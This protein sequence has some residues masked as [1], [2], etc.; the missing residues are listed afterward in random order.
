MN[1]EPVTCAEFGELLD[2]Y[3]DVGPVQRAALDA[4]SAGC[5]TCRDAFVRAT[6]ELSDLPCR[7]FVEL[8]TDYLERAMSARERARVSRHLEL[9]EGCRSYLA[10]IRTTIELAATPAEPPDPALRAALVAAFR[11]TRGGS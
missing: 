8:V 1:A 9:C 3:F 11:A 10:Q 7:A 4:H 6:E 5:A 2:H